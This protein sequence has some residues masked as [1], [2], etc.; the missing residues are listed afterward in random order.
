M[1]WFLNLSTRLKLAL[2]FS[3][4][5][6]LLAI[7]MV[8][9]GQGIRALEAAQRT[10]FERD[11]AI[12]AGLAELRADI[13]RQRISVLEMLLTTER[14]QQAAIEQGLSQRTAE[15]DQNLHDLAQRAR[16]DP[17]LLGDLATLRE[18][19]AAYRQGREAVL[20]L[21]HSGAL[22][23]AQ[24]AARG[25]AQEARFETLRDFIIK[26]NDDAQARAGAAVAS[27][28]A[29]AQSVLRRFAGIGGVALLAGVLLTYALAST[30]AE[31][32]NRIAGTAA[33]VA[34][35]NLVLDLAPA[36]RS[37]EVGRLTQ[38]FFQLTGTLR[39]QIRDLVEGITVLGSSAS[40]ISTSTSQLASSAAETA[41]AVSQTS[42]TVE[43]VKQ[44][45]QVSSQ[46]ARLVS[47][48][49]Q[50][51]AQVSDGGRQATDETAALMDRI[52]GQM[53]AIAESMVRLSEQ[54]AAVGQIVATV[55]DL[56]AQSKLLAV[57]ASIEA[58]KAGEHG[59]GF[60]VVA[61]EV[62]SLAE[63]SRQATGQV[64]ALLSDIQKAAGAAVLA[65]EQGSRAVE[66]GVQ[67]SRQAGQAIQTLAGGVADAAQAAAQ[68]AA[69]SQ[70]Q[71]VGVD[72]VASAM[73]NIRQASAQNVDSARQLEGAAH[74][75]K[76][77]G[78]T[79]KQL[80]ESYRF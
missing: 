46:K 7:A 6:A 17:R 18:K 58:A 80:T 71:L 63:Q 36:Q 73:A 52:Q 69:S 33:R 61:L 76:S 1:A 21:I 8:L 34:A 31:P 65:T 49:A 67:Q 55:E 29:L 77:L 13:N 28:E 60:A 53:E 54:S 24:Q 4:M 37:D 56:A 66:A 44:T 41:A 16:D 75:I 51:V 40:E 48:A 22:E 59:K 2:S 50:R 26:L 78:E 30:I 3:L 19:L 20:A 15:I 70:Q 45:A 32:L 72:Q 79:L 39:G 23:Q 35:G 64:R 38:A 43:E 62:K 12:L 5:L 27:S 42:S 74:N 10:V 14:G 47:E 25:G 68:I 9:A 57:N 11:V